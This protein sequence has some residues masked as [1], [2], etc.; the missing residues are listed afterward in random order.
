MSELNDWQII[1][2]QYKPEEQHLRESLCTLG[3]GYFASRGAFEFAEASY[4][5]KHNAHYPGTYIAGVFNKLKSRVADKEIENE[6]IVNWPNWLYLSFH[7]ED[8]SAFQIDQVDI[9]DFRQVLDLKRGQL[10]NELTFRDEKGRETKLKSIRI[11]SMDDCHLAA[12]KWELT[13]LNWSGEITIVSGIDGNVKNKGVPRY[14][15]LNGDHL[16]IVESGVFEDEEEE[17]LFMYSKTN[18]TEVYVSQAVLTDVSINNEDPAFDSKVISHDHLLTHHYKAS[19]QK[20]EVVHVSKVLAMYTSKDAGVGNIVEDAQKKV[21]SAPSIQELMDSH[22]LAWETIWNR[23]DIQVKG[24][25]NVQV[26]LRL[27]I[28]HL[29]QVASPNTMDLDVSVPSRG[30]HGE[31]YRGNLMW[32]ELYIFP[33]INYMKPSITQNMLKYRFYRM[34]EAR[35]SAQSDGHQG[36]MFPWQS[37]SNGEEN[38]QEIHLNPESG[39]WIPDNTHLQRHVNVAIA[40]NIWSYYKITNDR[41]FLE[42]YGAEMMFSITL[43]LASI[44]NYSEEKK[45]YE[46]RNVVGPDEYHTSYPDSDEPGLNNNAYTNIM[47]A[48]VMRQSLK[49]HERLPEFVVKNLDKKLGITIDT[50]ERWKE[51]SEQMFIPFIED[52]II[53]QFEGYAQLK[54]LDWQAYKEKYGNIQRLDR[55]LESEGDT[56]NCYKVSKQADVLMLFYLFTSFELKE[57]FDTLNYPFDPINIKKNI[58]YYEKRTSHGSS[59]SRLVYSWV[60]A[61]A[62]RKMS[63]K[64]FEE[65]L[66]SDFEDIQGGTTAEGIHLGAMAGTVD[67]VQRAYTGAYVDEKGVLWLNP[68]LPNEIDTISLSLRFRGQCLHV[69]ISKLEITL[70]HEEGWSDHIRVGIKDIKHLYE[71]KIGEEVS[72]TY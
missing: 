60:M 7:H 26:L 58:I 65:A 70:R 21:K 40:F 56:P 54:E 59:L 55:I 34:G 3:N 13:P 39:R 30:I 61:R 44:T 42:D 67:M 5:F 17:G 6:S 28:F 12:L 32:D 72:V 14:D 66:R 51:I 71:L 23:C 16:K 43:F 52:G 41:I 69:H 11:V 48:W 22:Y 63:W 37:G 64:F 31:A 68:S 35:R 38:A 29:L 2:Q 53:E 24:K 1:Y 46:I 45:R 9:L 4:D 36:A 8:G 25:D 47:V 20:G 10:I 49:M 18:N 57:I 15:D 62:H 19:V 33:V 27:H 50:L